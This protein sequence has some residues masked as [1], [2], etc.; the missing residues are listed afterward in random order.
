MSPSAT[1]AHPVV[2]TQEH[3]TFLQKYFDKYL[4]CPTAN[5][6]RATANTATDALIAQFAIVRKEEAVAIRAVSI[7]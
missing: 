6:R 1:K 3:K 5:E 4:E 7:L 2:L